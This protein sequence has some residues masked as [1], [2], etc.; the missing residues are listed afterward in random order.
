M[1]RGFFSWLKRL[2]LLDQVF[3]PIIKMA[4]RRAGSQRVDAKIDA[5]HS[6]TWMICGPGS[7]PQVENEGGR[8][9]N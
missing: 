7:R 3:E 9:T 8:I 6:S 5:S 2:C 4:Q 1:C